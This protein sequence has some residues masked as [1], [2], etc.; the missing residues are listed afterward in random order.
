LRRLP[1]RPPFS[2]PI[3][4]GR[5]SLSVAPAVRKAR[6]AR[7]ENCPRRHRRRSPRDPQRTL[8]RAARVDVRRGALR[9]AVEGRGTGFDGGA[10]RA[11]RRSLSH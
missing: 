1:R 9:D 6:P 11:R 3:E 10:P 4:H 5:D 8:A 7:C 2:I